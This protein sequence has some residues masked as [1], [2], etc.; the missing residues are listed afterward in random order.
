MT[1]VN[2]KVLNIEKAMKPGCVVVTLT[3]DGSDKQFTYVRKSYGNTTVIDG[4]RI[5]FDSN[6]QV[7]K[8]EREYETKGVKKMSTAKQVGT[9]SSKIKNEL[10]GKGIEIPKIQIPQV[11]ESGEV[12]H[13]RYEEIKCC[14]ECGIPVYLAGPAGSGKNHTVEQIANELGWNFYFSNSVQQEYKLTGFIDA[15]GEFHET[16]FYKACTDE[17]ECIFFLDE[18]DAS[19]PEVLVLL[20]A[21]IANGYFEFPNGRVDFDHVHFVAA[22]NTVGNGAD[23]MYTGRMVLDQATLDRFAIIEFDYCL[24]IEMAITKNNTELV[25]FIHQMRKEAESKGIRATF[26]YRCMTMITKLERKGMNLEMA[27]KISIVKGLDKDTINTFNP[28]GNT[29]YHN[30]LRK[31]QLAA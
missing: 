13:D 5:Y 23:D 29:K 26:S 9:T 30:A 22:G 14:L 10:E 12:H 15:G 8:V 21:A 28:S 20:N 6:Y 2:F 31:I 1:N 18:M 24:K 16:E 25:E 7:T 3:F 17:N 4:C 19:I 11:E 27:M